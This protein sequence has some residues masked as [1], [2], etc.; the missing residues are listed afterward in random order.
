MKVV[1]ALLVAVLLAG[2][3]SEPIPAS[4][5]KPTPTVA[6]KPMPTSEMAAMPCVEVLRYY[7]AVRLQREDAGLS[8]EGEV[9]WI[10]FAMLMSR[11]HDQ[12]INWLDA[13]ARVEECR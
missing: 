7:D 2:C 13:R 4:P 12:T 11:L 1:L 8:I 3:S 6:P 9:P 5:S 10:E